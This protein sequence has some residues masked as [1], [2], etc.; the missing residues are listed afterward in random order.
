MA[1]FQF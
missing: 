1:H